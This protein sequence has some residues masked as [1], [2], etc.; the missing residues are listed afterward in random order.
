MMTSRSAG[1]PKDWSWTH[2]EPH[3]FTLLAIDD[4]RAESLAGVTSDET[5]AWPPHVASASSQW[6]GCVP[7]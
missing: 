2:L 4:S 3:S 7:G 5:Y 1:R 6:G